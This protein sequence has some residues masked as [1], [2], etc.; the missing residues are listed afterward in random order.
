MYKGD[1]M[2]AVVLKDFT[3]T[4][5]VTGFTYN[6]PAGAVVRSVEYFCDG[7]FNIVKFK[8]AMCFGRVFT[9]DV[10]DIKLSTH[11]WLPAL[12]YF[13]IRNIGRKRWVVT[14]PDPLDKDT[15]KVYHYSTRREARLC[16]GYIKQPD[17]LLLPTKI[18][19]LGSE[20]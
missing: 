3:Y 8:S 1:Y 6:I 7:L 18:I 16:K 10:S 9:I 11:S 12:G 15:L 14:Q 4:D 13:A 5:N 17:E 19:D 2:K 20:V